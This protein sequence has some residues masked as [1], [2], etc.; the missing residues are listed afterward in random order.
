MRILSGE[1]VEELR[2]EQWEEQRGGLT[3]RHFR[4]AQ[5]FFMSTDYAYFGP[6][7]RTFGGPGAGGQ[8]F[9]VDPD[10]R[11]G[12]GYLCNLGYPR[13]DL[14]ARCRAVID[15]VYASL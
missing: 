15:A 8:V 12:F 6:N 11:L 2:V 13:V 9:F 5:G 4:M 10:A 3:D 1:Q 14:G 7:P